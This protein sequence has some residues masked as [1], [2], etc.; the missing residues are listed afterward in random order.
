M[1]KC[2]LSVVLAVLGIDSSAGPAYAV[3]SQKTAI[4]VRSDL[5]VVEERVLVQRVHHVMAVESLG[6]QR[7]TFTPGLE[8]LDVLEAWTQLGDGTT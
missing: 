1:I 4:H 7:I 6:H 8:Q 2:L 5:S 3:I